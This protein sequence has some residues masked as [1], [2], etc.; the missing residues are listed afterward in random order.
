DD[1]A[2]A[3]RPIRGGPQRRG[4]R[5]HAREVAVRC[6]D[7]DAV[8]GH[9]LRARGR[10]YSRWHPRHE[11]FQR[12]PLRIPLLRRCALRRRG[13]LMGWAARANAKGKPLTVHATVE[14]EPGDLRSGDVITI[15]ND[16][17]GRPVHELDPMTRKPTTRLK[18]F[19]IT[20]VE[21]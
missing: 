11:V 19:V 12:A 1:A 21:D 6:Q 16:G 2:S 14:R 9:S 17:Y 8:A 10:V 13:R 18:R 5:G 3:A 7:E 20:R 4:A 15:E